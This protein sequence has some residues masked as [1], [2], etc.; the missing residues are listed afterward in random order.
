MWNSFE[1]GQ[2]ASV[3]ENADGDTGLDDAVVCVLCGHE[4][5]KRQ[6]KLECNSCG[7]REDCSDLFPVFPEGY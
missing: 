5:D 4:M 3:S 6:C 2:Q 1:G 7:Y